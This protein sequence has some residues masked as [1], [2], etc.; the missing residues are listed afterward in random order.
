MKVLTAIAIAVAMLAGGVQVEAAQ[1]KKSAQAQKQASCEAQ[2]K[3]RYS[4][5]RFMAR[6]DFVRKCMGTTAT[7]KK[8]KPKP[9]TTGQR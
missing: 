5:V 1:N 6:R 2:A 8:A 9:A 4:A 7:A 3:K